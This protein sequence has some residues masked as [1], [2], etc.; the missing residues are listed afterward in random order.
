MN[1]LSSLKQLLCF[2]TALS[3]GASMYGCSQKQNSDTSDD[4]TPVVTENVTDANNSEPTSQAKLGSTRKSYSE[5]FSSRDK[6]QEG[7]PITTEIRLGS[8]ITI[9]GNGAEVSNN[10]IKITAEG[11]YR[12]TG[13]LSDGQ[14]IVNAPKAKVQLILDNADISCSSSSAIYGED[15]DKLFITTAKDSVN[16]LT[17]GDTAGAEEQL[18]CIFSSDSITLNGLGSLSINAKSSDGI[19]SKDDI[20]ITGGNI[21]IDAFGDGIKGKDYVAVC[22]G[23]VTVKCGE[24]GIKSTNAEDTA[25]GFVYIEDGSF[26]ITSGN[27]GIQAETDI[28]TTG[29]EFTITTG[30]GADNS[31]KAHMDDFGGGRG[32]FGGMNGGDRFGHGGF[33]HGNIPDDFDFDKMTP[34]DD[35]DPNQMTPPDGFAPDQMTPPDGFDPDQTPPDA[36]FGKDEKIPEN[37][38]QSS[39]DSTASDSMKGLKGCASIEI[40]GGTF[41]IDSED[42]S[43]HSNGDVLIT[44]GSITINSGDDGIH[45]DSAVKIGGSADINIAKSYEGI[46]GAVIEISGGKIDLTSED[47]GLNGSDGSY[48]GGM[49]TMASGVNV[50]ISGGELHVNAQGDGLDSNGDMTISGGTVIVDGPTN[51]G[52]GALDGNGKI[53]VNGGTLIA[54]GSSQMAECPDEDSEQ[55]SVA[56]GFDSTQTA[57]TAIALCDENGNQIVSYSTMKTFDHVVI[58]CPDIAKGKKYSIT[59]DGKEIQTFSADS[60]LTMLGNQSMTFGFGGHGGGKGD[61]NKGDFQ[62]PTD[63]N[64][65]P[66]LPEG[67]RFPGGKGDKFR[68][69]QS[70]S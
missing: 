37:S 51:G 22:G 66:A 69:D 14:I 6:N 16:T 11:V 70:V 13:Q 27:D 8:E 25:F 41:T 65:D 30:G 28:V 64:G 54:V 18:P 15:S 35:S 57:G 32:G 5:L 34:P 3:L 9:E 42:D 55:M 19:Q 2:I 52:N 60:T 56:Y 1:K 43:L 4:P 39:D 31:T 23:N 26:S 45:A 29:G 33:D 50:N 20:V 58:S 12:V 40:N 48:Q 62:M 44:D 67:G 47:D 21:N 68:G 10:Q 53:L 49:G 61:F 24:D 63:E 36:P 38:D 46:E 7:E 17:N 59:A